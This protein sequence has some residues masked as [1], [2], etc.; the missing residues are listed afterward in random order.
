MELGAGN[1]AFC[2]RS[3]GVLTLFLHQSDNYNL[4]SAGARQ[5]PT[6]R[7]CVAAEEV[8]ALSRQPKVDCLY[9]LA[10]LTIG[11]VLEYGDANQSLS[12]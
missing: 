4:R 3:D 1:L 2:S 12:L 5:V 11:L 10:S 8:R 6:C 9:A 7:K